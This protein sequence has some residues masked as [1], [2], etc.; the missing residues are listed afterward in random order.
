VGVAAEGTGV[1][2]D[3]MAAA[4]AAAIV[5][6]RVVAVMDTGEATADGVAVMVTTEATAGGAAV[7]EVSVSAGIYRYCP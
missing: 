4:A 6:A 1:A 2:E 5:A 3:F 7:G